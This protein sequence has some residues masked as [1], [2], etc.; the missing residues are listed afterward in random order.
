MHTEAEARGV[1]AAS[2]GWRAC[3]L[4][5]CL[6]DPAGYGLAAS[7]AEEAS[8]G[9][10]RCG[11][12]SA[13]WGRESTLWFP[14]L[15]GEGPGREDWGRR[16]QCMSGQTSAQHPLGCSYWKGLTEVLMHG[17]CAGKTQE[18]CFRVATSAPVHGAEQPGSVNLIKGISIF[19]INSVVRDLAPLN[20]PNLV[21]K[22]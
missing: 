16:P 6:C 13:P 10:R 3:V 5:A 4:P 20:S 12:R 17:R 11:C 8:C 7:L 1:C 9:W 14:R 18:K 22:F 19:I 2:A 21:L 15:P